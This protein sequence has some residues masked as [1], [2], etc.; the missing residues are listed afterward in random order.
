MKGR[1]KRKIPEKNLPTN[2]IVRPARFPHTRIRSDPAGDLTQI[3]L[4]GG[5]QANRSATV[6]TKQSR[7]ARAGETGDP[8]EKPPISGIVRQDS[9]MRKSVSDPAGNRYRFALVDD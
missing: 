4:V 7:N 8:R 6:S 2:G 9:H 3:V 1:G 5:E